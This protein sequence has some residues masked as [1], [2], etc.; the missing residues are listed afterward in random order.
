QH[1]VEIVRALK[2]NGNIVSMTG[3]GV[4]DAPSLTAA[5]IG[6]AMGI[7]GTDAAK[8]AADMILTDDNFATI[9]SAVEQGRNIY[10]NIK[11]SVLFLLTSNLGEVVAMFVS[12]LIG[13][14]APLIAT[15]L[16]WI[17][18]LTDSLPA[19]ALGMDPG[20]PDIMQEKPRPPQESFFA[21][22]AGL[23]ILLG[24]LLIG[25]LTIL[26]FW[27]GFHEHGYSPRDAA[28]PANVL[29]YAR[30]MAFMTI[31]ASQLF[32]S[33]AFRNRLKSIFQIGILKNRYLVGAIVLGLSLQLIVIG[34]P[35]MRHA[36]KLQMLAADGW[37]TVMLL[38]LVPLVLNE[39][40]KIVLRLKKKAG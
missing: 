29:D 14:P 17:N 13:L 7:T 35:A 20:D 24:G 27:L 33:L 3:D 38:G 16:L 23:R 37:L 15:Q 26:A 4:N 39:L 5:D 2:S 32:Y 8:S 6:V 11:K 18:L 34:T 12:I 21:H 31:I 22:G 9:I 28:I 36:F 25:L 40:F 10:N 19:V 30:S 1:K